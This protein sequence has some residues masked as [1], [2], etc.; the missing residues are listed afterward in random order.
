MMKKSITALIVLNIALIMLALLFLFSKNQPGVSSGDISDKFVPSVNAAAKTDLLQRQS[1]IVKASALASPAVV[2]I[3]VVKSGYVEDF[4]R[5]FLLY[6]YKEKVPYL[7]SGFII[8][9][10]GHILTNYHVIEGA[11]EVY[12]ALSDGRELK[13]A[14]LGADRV[15][16]VAMLKVEGS[17]F[18]SV[19]IGNSDDLIIG[20][21]ALALGNPFG[22]LIEDPRPTLTV[23]VI[24]ALNRSFRPDPSSGH[25]YL[26][27][28]QTDA[29]I[30]P[31]N[32]GGPL[33][34]IEG[35]VIGINT[36]IVS[37]TGASHGMGFAIPISRAMKIADEIKQYGKVRSLWLDFSCINLSP[38]LARLVGKTDTKGALIRAIE[39]NGEA[40]RAGLKVGDVIIKANARTIETAPD[41][42]GYISALQVGD[43][44]Q[45]E[46]F[47]NGEIVSVSYI[48]KE[49]QETQPRNI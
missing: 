6:P 45:F 22:A 48:I 16:D 20:E 32:S 23:G 41:L 31:G 21:W 30:N 35:K 49:Y 18:P 13:G 24:S 7:G 38:Y 5:P 3:S 1:Q 37:K 34:N 17:D 11:E 12:V 46:V 9:D 39:R 8:D 19:T 42:L 10:K 25:V 40:E 33:L 44:I 2:S 43:T 29:A 36:F 27:M 26:N 4:F 28:I 47:R 14:V 15:N